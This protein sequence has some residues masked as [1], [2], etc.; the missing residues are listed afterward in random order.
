MLP[1]FAGLIVFRRSDIDLRWLVLFFAFATLVETIS[2]MLS[3]E[4]KNN[5]WLLNIYL[6]IECIVFVNMLAF[7]HGRP[8]VRFGAAVATAT[9]AAFWAVMIFRLGNIFEVNDEAF[10]A[11]ALLNVAFAGLALYELS[12]RPGPSLLRNPRFWMAA[13]I[14]I[15]YSVDVTIF[16][17]FD[18]VTRRGGT[19]LRSMYVIHSV[20]NIFANTIYAVGFLCNLQ[21]LKSR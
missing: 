3:A 7:W 17:I 15:F 13:G 12:G 1:L 8:G 9:Y 5:V 14:L 6:L 19:T 11:A 16:S 2:R 18:L 21:Q 20:L 10:T 4:Y